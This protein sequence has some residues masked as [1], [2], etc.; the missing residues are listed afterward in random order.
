[1]DF[2]V[3]QLFDYFLASPEA[4]PLDTLH[5]LLHI[6]PDSVSAEQ[7]AIAL[8]ALCKLGFLEQTEQGYRHR[9]DPTLVP[10]RLRC[11]NRGYCFAIRDEPDVDDVYIYASNLNGAWNGD[12]VLARITKDGYRRRSPEGEVAAVIERVN[13][14]L[15]ARIQNQDTLVKAIPL[16]DRL[17]FEVELP[18]ETP[19]S[20]ADGQVVYVEITR[21]PLANLAT[22]GRVLKVLGNDP[23]FSMDVDLICSKY[24]LPQQFPEAVLQ[25]AQGLPKGI[26]KAEL[27]KRQDYRDWFTLTM[28]AHDLNQPDLL[29][30]TVALSLRPDQ[31]HWQLGI[32]VADVAAWVE[33]GSPLAQEARRRCRSA[34]LDTVTLPLYPAAVTQHCL[35]L[36]QQERLCW[37]VLV[38]LS[39]EGEVIT[40]EVQPSVIRTSAHLTFA[41]VEALLATELG[42]QPSDLL[43]LLHSL[44]RLT[45]ALRQRRHQQGGF[46]VI[47]DPAWTAAIV[48]TPTP[49][50]PILREAEVL[51]E[52]LLGEHL[53]RLGLPGVAYEQPQP[54]VE[55][56]QSFLRLATQLGL[57]TS[58]PETI[59]AQEV[60]QWLQQLPGDPTLRGIVTEALLGGLPPLGYREVG[61]E[62]GG[63]FSR[64]PASVPFAAP[65]HRYGDWLNQQV[66]QALCF[67]GKEKSAPRSKTVADLRSRSSHGVVTWAVLPSKNQEELLAEVRA[68]LPDAQAQLAHIDQA[69]QELQGLKK[70]AFMQAHLGQ[71]LNGVI[72]RV[73]NYGFFVQVEPLLAE[74]LVHVRSLKDDWYEYHPKYQA[75]IGRKN[76]KQFRVGERVT[77]QVKSVDYYRQQTD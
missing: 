76:R 31:D 1:M 39:A 32:H 54:T 23:G 19:G 7:L 53:L 41:Q 5:T 34:H 35:L 71:T 8:E 27:K 57:I 60:Q 52:A 49:A 77:V 58:P 37:S 11:Y 46:T 25:A 15:V 69:E 21:Y 18:E 20:L 74:G 55:G 56:L 28:A 24:G 47:G 38:T 75:L 62:G 45:Q 13:L 3:A 72:V 14:T 9:P 59:T 70:S 17:M 68:W 10:A 48:Q 51:A 64:P 44:H 63:V 65:L 67:K 2:P 26:S 73:Q 16:D 22:Q 42:D 43:T 30:P 33:L 50:Q 12:R 29:G 66:L 40:Y 6:A 61:G 36:P 4:T